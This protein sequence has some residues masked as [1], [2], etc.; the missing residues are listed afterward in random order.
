MRFYEDQDISHVPLIS[1]SQL[2][3]RL[4]L[5]WASRPVGEYWKGHWQ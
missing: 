1:P 4:T 3:G 5:I 2:L